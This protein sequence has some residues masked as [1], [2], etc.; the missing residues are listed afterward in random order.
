VWSDGTHSLVP[1]V[2]YER[3]N[4]AS[5]FAAQPAGLG[6]APG[7]LETVQTVGLNF[8]LDPRV[9]FKADYQSFLESD[10]DRFDLGVGL[11]F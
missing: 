5:D 10:D 4:T 7:V 3:Y 6:A 2:R 1:F 11:Q 8:Y 9:V